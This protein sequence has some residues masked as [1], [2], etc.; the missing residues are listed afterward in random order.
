MDPNDP[1]LWKMPK[2]SK[3]SVSLA[4]FKVAPCTENIIRRI[5]KSVS[6]QGPSQE[7]VIE[8]KVTELLVFGVTDL[9]KPGI[10]DEILVHRDGSVELKYNDDPTT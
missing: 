6:G 9:S 2:V 5:Q 8:N 3:L 7:K 10:T 1:E 4:G